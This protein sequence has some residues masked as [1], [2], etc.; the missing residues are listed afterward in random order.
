MT[1]HDAPTHFFQITLLDIPT[2]NCTPNTTFHQLK[3]LD[4]GTKWNHL[5]EWN[6]DIALLLA[7]ISTYEPSKRLIWFPKHP[8]KIGHA[9]QDAFPKK[10]ILV[11]LLMILKM[12]F[13]TQKKKKRREILVPKHWNFKWRVRHCLILHYQLL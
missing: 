9:P 2:K 11:T 5:L 3:F 1:N 8:I 4:C 12:R 10:G 6:P 13:L 7:W